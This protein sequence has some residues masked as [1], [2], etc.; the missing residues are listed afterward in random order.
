M[1]VITTE[2]M[3]SGRVRLRSENRDDE[4]HQQ[5]QRGGDEL[6]ILEHRDQVAEVAG[7]GDAEGR[8]VQR[9]DEHGGAGHTG[10]QGVSTRASWEYIP[11]D[12]WNIAEVKTYRT[13]WLIWNS[14]PTINARVTLRPVA[15]IPEPTI[16]KMPAPMMPPMAI[17]VKSKRFIFFCCFGMIK[18][19]SFK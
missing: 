8:P 17:K 9:A 1:M 7:N 3:A 14:I 16:V 4:E 10:E 5:R 12:T 2:P 11:P 19:V 18:F 13:C 15:E 6:V